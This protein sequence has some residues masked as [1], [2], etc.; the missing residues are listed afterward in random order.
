M[1]PVV[2]GPPTILAMMAR[3]AR[4][5]A[6]SS[7]GSRIAIA[8]EFTRLTITPPSRGANRTQAN[9]V[10]FGMIGWALAGMLRAVAITAH[11]RMAP[12][13]LSL[14]E[15]STVKPPI[16][17]PMIPNA[18]IT[19]PPQPPNSPGDWSY[20]RSRTEPIHKAAAPS[21]KPPAKLPT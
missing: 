12:R 6:R 20:C 4:L 17:E 7:F 8:V 9:R 18:R 1:T 14:W 13:I 19:R 5:V 2:T 16:I 15:R 21:A 3:A 11:S 10:T